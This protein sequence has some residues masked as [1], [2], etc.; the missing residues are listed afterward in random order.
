MHPLFDPF[1]KSVIAQLADPLLAQFS[2]LNARGVDAFPHLR[3][4]AAA[5][6]VGVVPRHLDAAENAV[7]VV[8]VEGEK[9]EQIAHGETRVARLKQLMGQR[10]IERQG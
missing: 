3:R 6:R 10:Q 2:Q 1:K 9:I 4:Q 8:A 5:H 7:R